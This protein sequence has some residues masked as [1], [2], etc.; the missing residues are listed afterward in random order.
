MKK[1]FRKIVP[2]IILTLFLAAC[3]TASAQPET[4]VTSLD[5]YTSVRTFVVE[6][7][8]LICITYVG[9]GISCNWEG[10]EG[11]K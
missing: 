11:N 6:G 4:E 1:T 7:Y 5:I 2:T 3:G 8:P 10:W 9:A